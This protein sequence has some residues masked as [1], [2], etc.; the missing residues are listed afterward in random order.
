M[1][2]ADLIYQN[3]SIHY[4]F[5]SG[6]PQLL[7]CCHGYD[8]SSISFAFLQKL[9]QH[10]S[11][12][13]I[14]LPFHGDTQWKEERE[15]T[16][17]DLNS[18]IDSIRQLHFSNTDT[19]SLLGFSLGSR[20]TLAI[21]QSA[22]FNVKR[23]VL[24]A[25]DGIRMNFWY[26]FA[27]QTRVGNRVFR[28]SA[29]HPALIFGFLNAANKLRLINQSVYKFTKY[30]LQDKN[31]R[32]LLYKRWTGMRKIKP[33]L[34]Q[35]KTIVKEK[36]LMVDLVYGE[37]DRIIKHERAQKFCR[38][39]GKNCK[40]HIIGCGHQVLHE[41]NAAFIVQLLSSSNR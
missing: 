3:S 19:V 20:L 27:T 29:E 10:F 14:D 24:L 37:Y 30:Y 28:F 8:E 2:E 39:L 17:A 23:I 26:W 9:L 5:S 34:K 22:H 33:D 31:S 15:L 25:P 12:L 36:G 1:Q 11:F 32:T 40:L 38:E 4:R 7:I 35:I 18:I 21:L 41:K 6:G 13:C 16:I